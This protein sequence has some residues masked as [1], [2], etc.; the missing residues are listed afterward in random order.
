MIDKAQLF[1]ARPGNTQT[2]TVGEFGDFTVRALTRS[3]ALAVQGVQLDAAEMERRLLALALV[4]P[5][6]TED[7]VRQWQDVAPAGELEPLTNR[8]AE[9][10]GMK[11][12][13]VKEAVKRFPR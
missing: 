13:A 4:D 11:V 9:L 2:V 10:S 6:L 8:I 12:G 7:E 3:E 5:V 1:A